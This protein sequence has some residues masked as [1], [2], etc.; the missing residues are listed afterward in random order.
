LVKQYLYASSFQSCVFFEKKVEENTQVFMRIVSFLSI[1]TWW[2]RIT[3]LLSLFIPWT[4]NSDTS[5]G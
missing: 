3:A 1:I 5:V 2:K 4:D